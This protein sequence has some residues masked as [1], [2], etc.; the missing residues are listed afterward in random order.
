MPAGY[1]RS[2][3]PLDS[4][5]TY[6]TGKQVWG[7]PVPAALTVAELKRLPLSVTLDFC[8][9][10]LRLVDDHHLSQEQVDQAVQ[11]AFRPEV[12]RRIAALLAGGNRVLL[13]P[14]VLLVLIKYAPRSAATT[15]CPASSPGT[16][17]WP[18]SVSPTTW[19]AAVTS[20]GSPAWPTPITPAA[21]R[22]S[23]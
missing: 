9:Q 1:T 6:L 23:S 4:V 3:A 12:W 14:Q 20:S 7:E 15:C 8:A 17:C 5:A 10:L 18:C 11:A 2:P 19:R 16:L 13:A 21:C 22:T